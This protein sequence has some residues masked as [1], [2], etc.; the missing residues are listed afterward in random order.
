M[1]P[2]AADNWA[3]FVVADTELVVVQL[4]PVGIPAEGLRDMVQILQADSLAE[5]QEDNPVAS[6]GKSVLFHSLLAD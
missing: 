5:R 3:H 4:Q 2:L 6:E 1:R